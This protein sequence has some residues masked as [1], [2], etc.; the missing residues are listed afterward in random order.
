MSFEPDYR[1]IVD[2]VQNKRSDRLSLYE[3]IISPKIMEQILGTEFAKF[4]ESSGAD[5]ENFFPEFC[6]FFKEMTF[7][8]VSYEW[9]IVAALPADRVPMLVPTTHIG[10]SYSCF[11]VLITV[12]MSSA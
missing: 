6:R 8:T 9:C 7:D 5:L 4:E 12:L 2:V 3:H 1:N 10:K 11:I